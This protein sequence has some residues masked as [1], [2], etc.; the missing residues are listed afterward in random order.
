MFTFG[1]IYELLNQQL[2]NYVLYPSGHSELATKIDYQQY[3]ASYIK[4]SYI[5]V[6][7]IVLMNEI[8]RYR[9]QLQAVFL[10]FD[11]IQNYDIPI[12]TFGVG[13]LQVNNS[14]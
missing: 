3:S 9:F 11:S 4:K 12:L 5:P 14:R 8:T 6:D 10:M 7:K 2:H 13:S 1:T